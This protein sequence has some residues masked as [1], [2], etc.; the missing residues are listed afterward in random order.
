MYH[1]FFIFV[2]YTDSENRDKFGYYFV[3]EKLYYLVITQLSSKIPINID[4]SY[5]TFLN[6]LL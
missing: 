2:W 1:N 3:F 4:L 5:L 6:K